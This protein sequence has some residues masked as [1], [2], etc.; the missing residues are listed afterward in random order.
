MGKCILMVRVST[1]GQTIDAQHDEL[2]KFAQEEGYSDYILVEEQGASAY[3]VDAKY[4]KMI[5]DIKSLIEE[6]KDIDCLMVWAL[7]R[8][9]R[10]QLAFVDLETFLIE[11]KVNLIVKNPRMRL[12]RADGSVDS[13]IEMA[14][15]L[16]ALMA[17]QEVDEMKAKFKRARIERNNRGQATGRHRFGYTTDANGYIIIDE[18]VAPTIRLAF[19]LYLSGLSD[20]GVYRELKE[21]GTPVKLSLLQKIMVDEYYIGKC[22]YAK[23]IPAIIDE[24]TFNAVQEKRRKAIRHQIKEQTLYGLGS[25]ITKCPKCGRGMMLIGGGS[26]KHY[27]RCGAHHNYHPDTCDCKLNIKSDIMDGLLWHIG[28]ELYIK[29]I[30]D[31]QASKI[32]DNKAQI[33]TN[34]T[35]INNLKIELNKAE[36]KALRATEEYVM[37]NLSKER[38]EA[39][40]SKINKEK[41]AIKE[42][43]TKYENANIILTELIENERRTTFKM[44]GANEWQIRY[45]STNLKEN[46]NIVRR[47]VQEVIVLE[48]IDKPKEWLKDNN[49]IEYKGDNTYIRKILKLKITDVYNNTDTYIMSSKK[50]GYDD[51]NLGYY[52]KYDD[53]KFEIIN[54][55]KYFRD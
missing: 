20:K 26:G 45:N 4:K 21:R 8:A 49:L 2:V 15:N 7:N 53:D 41:H 17:K 16:L 23:N 55:S 10:N 51:D 22:T 13:G 1:E 34:N 5:S 9:F 35:K 52:L 46:C 42:S 43:I 54:A 25:T 39:L 28:S 12:L 38:K 6:D 47:F 40:I 18:S 3:K 29:Y 37:G 30:N 14:V 48:I 31:E 33:D 11:H 44:K 32:S 27:Y 19:T 50:I 36:D 24:E